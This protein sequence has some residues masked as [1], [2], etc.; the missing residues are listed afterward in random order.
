[1]EY[2]KITKHNLVLDDHELSVVQAGLMLLQDGAPLRNGTR[3]SEYKQTA[4]T[5][6]NV[7]TPPES[8]G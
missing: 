5:M 6:L 2:K 8:A 3:F 4:T 7:T 1:M